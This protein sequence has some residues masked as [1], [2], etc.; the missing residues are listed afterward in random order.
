MTIAKQ[1]K[2]EEF[3]KPSRSKAAFPRATINTVG[4]I[5]FN[6]KFL[7]KYF[8]DKDKNIEN[9]KKWHMIFYYD[10]ENMMIGLRVVSAPTPYSN[11][12]R[13]LEKGKG[14]SVSAR[15]FLNEYNIQY[16]KKTKSYHI[17]KYDK[18]DSALFFII[19]LKKSE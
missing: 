12:I 2:F 15:A 3:K 17:E 4:N 19:D 16:A 6:K 8:L 1:S 7:Q 9:A 11:P 5:N 13:V 14:M 18:A 10:K